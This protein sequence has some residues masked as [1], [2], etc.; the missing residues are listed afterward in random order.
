MSYKRESVLTESGSPYWCT[1]A[2]A[3][4]AADDSHPFWSS[5]EL[6]WPTDLLPP[7]SAL[8]D[9]HHIMV[10]PLPGS[11]SD[12]T[13]LLS[14]GQ[15]CHYALKHGAE[16]YGK[17][18]YSSSFGFSCPTGMFGLEQ[19]AADS[20]LAL[21]DDPQEA[22]YGEGERWRVRRDPIDAQLKE[23]DGVPYLQ[24]KW[25]PWPD[26]SVE[27][28]LFPPA[29]N[30]SCWYLRVHR[31]KSG[32]KLRTAEGGWAMHGQGADGRAIVQVFSGET[33]AGG[34]EA[35]GEA[36]AKTSAGVIGVA[37][38]D[39]NVG[40]QLAT[41]GK[42]VQ[43]DPNSNIIF[44]R[45]VLPTLLGEVEAGS[46]VWVATA[47]YAVAARDDKVSDRWE[48]EWQKRPTVPSW[49]VKA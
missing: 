46:T 15:S 36:R 9:P 37:T 16:K 42:L 27:T 18:A 39:L 21:C 29:S 38:V 28:W 43:S 10:R 7:V 11:I 23:A 2:F 12:H 45:T 1:K 32:R 19:L 30:S 25:Q 4:L 33:S 31:I 41:K 22:G 35:R 8:P 44:P 6:P 17:F 20:M 26:V 34:L 40:E 49:V 24:S 47:V 13:Y 3:C 48:D 14:S 5:K